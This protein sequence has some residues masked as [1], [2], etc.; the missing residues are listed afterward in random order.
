MDHIKAIPKASVNGNIRRVRITMQM[1][2]IIPVVVLALLVLAAIFAPLLAP[3]PSTQTSLPNRLLP[4][5]FITGG[6][7]AHFLGTDLVGRDILSRVFY[8][9]RVSLSVSLIVILITSIIGT[10]LGIMAGYLGGRADTG[11]MRITDVALAFPQILIA[12]LLAVV[13]GPSFRTVVLALSILGWAPYA[14]LIRGEVLRVRE[15]DFIAQA[16]IIGSSTLRI[17]IK[18]IFPNVVNPLIIIATMSVGLVILTESIL[19]YLGAGI[20]PPNPSWGS[21][22]SDGRNLIDKAWWISVFPGMAIGLVVLSG[23]FLGDW[24]RDKLDPRLRQL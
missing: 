10:I 6:S 1:T 21:M 12:L 2:F 3:Y 9:A 14:R 11:L 20:P 23:N 13:L 4:P 8:G 18:H 7:T 19:S 24:I 5:F 16:R 17:M 15:A 22:V